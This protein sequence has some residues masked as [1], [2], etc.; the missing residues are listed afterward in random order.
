M[1][2]LFRGVH[3]NTFKI[4]IDV[5]LRHSSYNVSANQMM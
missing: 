4:G 3:V 1:G 2:S 5:S